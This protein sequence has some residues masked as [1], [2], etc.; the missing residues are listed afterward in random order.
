MLLMGAAVQVDADPQLTIVPQGGTAWLA[1]RL[2]DDTYNTD[3]YEGPYAGVNTTLLL[4][5]GVRVIGVSIGPSDGSYNDFISDYHQDANQVA[6]LAYSLSESFTGENIV[7]L[8]L[9][10]QAADNVTAGD[11]PVQFDQTGVDFTG[12]GK[13]GNTT[14][15]TAGKSGL[16]NTDGVPVQHTVADGTMTI[17]PSN[18]HPSAFFQTD[19]PPAPFIYITLVDDEGIPPISGG[20][21][22]LGGVYAFEAVDANGNPATDFGDD[23]VTLTMSYDPDDLNGLDE[24]SLTIHYYD[25]AWMP[26]SLIVDLTTPQ[27]SIK[28]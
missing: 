25:G 12:V 4:P 22:L 10:V 2:I 11:Y 26:L 27:K 18:T 21:Q 28:L 20:L 23:W 13:D 16:A 17:T 14:K 6:V 3:S 15:F 24:Q 5:D 1:L 19:A 7:L 9:N 8:R